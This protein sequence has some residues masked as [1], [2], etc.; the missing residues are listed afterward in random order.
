MNATPKNSTIALRIAAAMCGYCCFINLYSPQ[1]VLPFLQKEFAASAAQIS[2]LVTLSVLAVALTAPFTGTVADVL[3]RRRVIVS[4]MMVVGIPAVLA[5]LSSSLP[6]LMV[7]RFVQGLALPPIFAVTIAYLGEELPPREATAA[8]GLYTAGASLGG[9]SGRFFSGLI[10]DVAGWRTAFI[11]LAA[12]NVAGAI[13][14]FFLLPREK[15][16]V[17]SE[18]LRESTRQMLQHLRN[19]NL[20]ATYAVGFGVLFSFICIFTFVNFHLAAP[21]YLLTPSMLGAI[22]LVYLAGSASA[23]LVGR[24]VAK[25]G[26]RNLMIEIMLLWMVGCAL[27]LADPL[28]AILLGLALCAACGLMAQAVSTGYIA[29]TAQA[30][31]SSAIGLY[32]T[33]F[34]VGGA[35]GGALGGIAWTFGNYPA[36]VFLTMAMLAGIVMVVALFW[37][38]TAKPPI[39]PPVTPA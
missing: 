36:C 19:R 38:P 27:T 15:H 7:W 28:W 2:W 18:G 34:Y 3:G 39:A 20:L 9:F 23:P 24:A 33:S 30:G 5:A 1:A 22:F 25:F 32:A 11:F 14:V 31:R 37:E 21:P 10:T 4:A 12:I 8:I 17:K 35:F 16:F 26:R 13:V 29:V 6:E